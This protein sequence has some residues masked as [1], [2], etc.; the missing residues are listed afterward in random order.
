MPDR[1]ICDRTPEAGP[2]THHGVKHLSKCK[3]STLQATTKKH[4]PK[5]Y[6]PV[7]GTKRIIAVES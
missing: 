6:R 4:R 2:S 3:H 1:C 5:K 7:P